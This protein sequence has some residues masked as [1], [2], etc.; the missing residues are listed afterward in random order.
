MNGK[1]IHI[2]TNVLEEEHVP[3][4]LEEHFELWDVD[5]ELESR[6]MIYS[7]FLRNGS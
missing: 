5:R 7:V 6:D 3:Q 1:V 4:V 2:Y